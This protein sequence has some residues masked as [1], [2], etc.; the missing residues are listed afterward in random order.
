MIHKET[1]RRLKSLKL[2]INFNK[3]LQTI[4]IKNMK[5]LMFYIFN[6]GNTLEEE[7]S[8]SHMLEVNSIVEI[9]HIEE[10]ETITSQYS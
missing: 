3:I 9:E 1:V 8:N 5:Y 4:I 6:T 7:Y 10:T 2:Q